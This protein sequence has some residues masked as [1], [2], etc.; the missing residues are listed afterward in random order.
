MKLN[1]TLNA[2]GRD[3]DLTATVDSSVTVGDLARR[4][5]LSDPLGVHAPPSGDAQHTVELLDPVPRLLD[6]RAAVSESGLRSGVRVRVGWVGAHFGG[7]AH[8]VLDLIVLDGPDRGRAFPVTSGTSYIGRGRGCEVQLNDALASRHHARLVVTDVVEIVDMGSANGTLIGGQPVTRARLLPGD[9]IVIGDTQ[10]TVVWK[11][12][13][14]EARVSSTLNGVLGFDGN[15]ILFSRSPVVSRV[16]EAKEFPLPDLPE[17]P[18]RSP[19]PWLMATMP[20]LFAVVMY[21]TTGNASSLLFFLLMPLML[22]GGALES[23]SHTKREYAVSLREFREDVGKIADRIRAEQAVEHEIRHEEHPSISDCLASVE[24]RSSRLWFR[25]RDLPRYLELRVGLGTLPSRCTTEMPQVGRSKA[26]AWLELERATAGLEVIHD[27]PIAVA[28]L[29]DG[30]IGVA[31]RRGAALPVAYSLVMQAVALHSPAELVVAGFASAAS[32]PSWDFL[33]WLPHVD[34][35]QSPIAGQHLAATGPACVA[36]ADQ[37]DEIIAVRSG[38]DAQP[39]AIAVLVIIEGDAPIDRSRLVDIAERGVGKGVAVLWLAEGQPRL[40]AVCTSYVLAEEGACVGYVRV[41]ETVAPVQLELCTE[42]QAASTARLMAPLI[43]AGVR[44]EDASDLPRQVSLLSLAGTE[45]AS[46]PTSVVERWRES[47]SVLTGPFAAEP[48]RRPANLRALIGQSSL[49]AFSLDLRADGPHALVGGTTGSGK[50]ELLQ[51]WILGMATAHSPQRVTFLLVDYKG[52]SAFRECT[53]LPHTLGL[54]TDL[55]PHLVRRALISLSAELRYR[56]HLLAR[57]K[58]KDLLE[59]ERRGEVETPPSLVIIVDEFA[60]LVQEVP[61]FVDGV[62][63]VAQR[64]RSLGLHLIL[65]TQR[66]AGV[67]KENLRANTNLRVALRMADESDSDDVLGSTQAAFFDP[68]VPGRAVSKSGPARLTPFQTGYAGGW[69]SS[70]PPAPEMS[71][72]TL[73]FG[74]S[75]DWPYEE[76]HAVAANPGPTDIQRLVTCVKEAA[77]LA[78]L[79]EPRKPWLPSLSTV[80][81]LAGLPS[82]RRDDDFTYGMIDLPDSQ[83]Q[84]TLSFRADVEG[85]LAVFGVSG[86]GTSTL[87]RTIAVAAGYTINGGPCQVYGLDFGNRDLQVLEG[88]PHVGSIINGSDHERVVRLI[89]HLEKEV[90]RRRSAYQS[91]NAGSIGDY[92]RLAGVPTEPRVFLLV[93]GASAFKQAYEVSGRYQWLDRLG[94]IAGAG[95]PLG[96]HLILAVDQKGGLP[97]SLSPAIQSRIIMRMGADDYLSLGVPEDVLTVDSPAGRGLRGNDEIQIAV[98]GGSPDPAKQARAI[99]KFGEAARRAGVAAAPGI[100]SLAERIELRDLPPFSGDRPVLGVASS[101]LLPQTF[102]PSGTFIVTGPPG[103]GRTT[104]VRTVCIATRQ[105]LPTAEYHL[106]TLK[107][108]SPVATLGIWASVT[109]GSQGASAGARKLAKMLRERGDSTP[110]VVV[111]ERVDELTADAGEEDLDDLVR[112]CLEQEHFV[113]AEADAQFFGGSY[114]LPP[115]LR[116]SRTGIVLHPEGTEGHQAFRT[117]LPPLDRSQLPTGRGFYVTKGSVELVQVAIP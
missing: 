16:F 29:T 70:T 83:E 82:R 12:K 111:L 57:F 65:A 18:R 101:T 47:R 103:S 3:I 5:A 51:A 102:Y 72:Q 27:V 99:V 23:R 89:T 32:A 67:I 54:V 20:L 75:V 19:L 91:V 46:S 73:S 92:R 8:A 112:V 44:S 45:L 52:G 25:R 87:L 42:A 95:R 74:P 34:S 86:A 4:I 97:T 109:V 110:V 24:Q 10:F 17:R 33:K 107:S 78:E 58:A 62:V 68:A 6:P 36:L 116:T 11:D 21:F 41:S 81:D 26:D 37:L 93:D 63:N 48:N 56:E 28:P 53:K 104:A 96:I 108:S 113:V 14:H 13:Q 115:R 35:P 64:G 55:S 117:D 39:W 88:M 85:N 79:P 60:A 22:L 114:G 80:Y 1:L 43:D 61:D 69:T 50:S 100:E 105:A 15:Q 84:P 106:L 71:V 2:Q 49:G 38:R 31:G 30:A 76:P 59:L 90:E 77:D 66:P 94:A 9:Q 40:P 7:G 98:L